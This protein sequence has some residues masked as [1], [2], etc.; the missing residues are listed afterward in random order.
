MRDKTRPS[1][2]A[3][4]SAGDHLSDDEA[5]ALAILACVWR[6]APCS[7]STRPIRLRKAATFPGLQGEIA[8]RG[9]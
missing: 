6:A 2:V 4:H 7:G 9:R 5:D 1:R 3:R 8:L